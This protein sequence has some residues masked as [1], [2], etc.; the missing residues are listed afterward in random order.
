MKNLI[1]EIGTEELPAGFLQPALDQLRKNFTDKAAELEL[2]HGEVSV[3]GTPR[4]LALL[5]TDL[6]DKQP[7]R[8][9]EFFGPSK[10]AGFDENGNPTKAALGFAR[11]K[12]SN[13]SE[14]EVVDTDKG[15]YLVVV[16]ELAG[17]Q[18]IE[19]LPELLH[20]LI[21]EFSFA[22]SMR[23]GV[24]RH[25]FGRPIQW[26]LALYGEECIHFDFDG[27]KSSNRTWGHR[28]MANN[29]IEIQSQKS[30]EDQLL[31]SYVIVDPAKRREK[32]VSEIKDAVAHYIKNSDAVVAIDET[33]ADTVTNLVESPYGV[34]GSFEDRFLDLP[35]DVLI[36]SMREHQKY[37]PVVDGEGKLLPAFVAVNNTKVNDIGLTRT[38]HERVLRARLEDA[39]FFFQSDKNTKLIDKCDDLSGIIFQAKL[40][41]MLEKNKRIIKLTT[42][43]AEKL[44]PELTDD[45]ARAAELCKAD[46]L[47]DMVGEFPSLQG[48]MGGAY[49]LNDGESETVA[50]AIKEHYMPKR[51]GAE[52][53]T[54]TVGT[55]IGMADRLDT[56]AGCF[57]IGQIPTGTA[58]PFGLRRLSLALLHIIEDRGYTLS[59]REVIHKALALYGDKVNGSSETVENVLD[60]IKG[61]FVNDKAAKG[62]DQEAIDAVTSVLFDDVNDCIKRIEAF[63]T[64]K[65]EDAFPVLA[66]SFKR[67]RNICKDNQATE[68]DEGFLSEEPELELKRVFDQVSK[69]MARLLATREYHQALKAMMQLKEP[70]DR[71]FD[72]VMVMVDDQSI[73]QNRLNL[74]TAIGELVLQVGDISKMQNST[75]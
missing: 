65:N 29:E 20:S 59:L 15:E 75:D 36:T 13:V 61:R 17:R 8:E 66:S 7:D 12:G 49:A 51:A 35:D 25:T 46:L 14:L 30:Y 72:H 33:L 16:K 37:F 28:F 38:G 26:L 18:T 48:V 1:F 45:A 43:L 68:I 42:L 31:E 73:R 60:F 27:I 10:Q 41:S 64:I 23:W 3:M 22:K 47:S 4:R 55:L 9:E 74:L 44:A 63:K 58:D 24:G 71:F 11:S 52:L 32:V 2:S 67:I 54:E 56:V 21:L 5:V 34:C 57:G 70:V 19:L 50:I 6:N 69:E 62:I 40:G 39:L 53:P